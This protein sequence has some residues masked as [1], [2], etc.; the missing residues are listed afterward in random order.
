MIGGKP[1]L[2]ISEATLL[3][4][5]HLVAIYSWHDPILDNPN[6]LMKAIVI[7]GQLLNQGWDRPSSLEKPKGVSRVRSLVH[8][9]WLLEK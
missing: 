9:D 2:I 1:A 4:R 3:T 7:V 6:I 8:D 5:K